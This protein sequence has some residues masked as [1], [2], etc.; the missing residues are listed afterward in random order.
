MGRFEIRVENVDQNYIRTDYF[1]SYI[2]NATGR[3]AEFAFLEWCMVQN[4]FTYFMNLF[5]VKK[6]FLFYLVKL[7][8]NSI[9]FLRISSTGAEFVFFSNGANFLKIKL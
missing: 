5:V 4:Y 1:T 7:G 6:F 9:F 3:V 8:T 2:I